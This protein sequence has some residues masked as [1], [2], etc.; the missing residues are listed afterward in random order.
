MACVSKTN[1]VSAKKFSHED[2]SPIA[3]EVH[4]SW[5]QCGKKDIISNNNE[6]KQ[7]KNGKQPTFKTAASRDGK[8]WK[9]IT[10]TQNS[11]GR[12]IER[13]RHISLLNS[14][15]KA[16]RYATRRQINSA[17][18]SIVAYV[19]LGSKL[20]KLEILYKYHVRFHTKVLKFNLSCFTDCS[21]HASARALWSTTQ[22]V[23]LLD[24]YTDKPKQRL[25]T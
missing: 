3:T 19:P 24:F 6:A 5:G 17:D 13:Q 2:L 23:I 10:R 12:R 25:Q 9:N 1:L 22:L 21:K 18:G 20:Q 15:Q 4:S 7:F 16:S 11:N 14:S 8:L